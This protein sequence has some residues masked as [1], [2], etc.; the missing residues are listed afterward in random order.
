[1]IPP[2]EAWLDASRIRPPPPLRGR[3]AAEGGGM[4]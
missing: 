4:G 1:M 2:T 3:V